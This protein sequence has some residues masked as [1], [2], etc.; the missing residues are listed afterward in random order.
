MNTIDATLD[1]QGDNK[2]Q[3][4]VA[5]GGHERQDGGPPQQPGLAW[6]FLVSVLVVAVFGAGFYTL[7]S[8]LETRKFDQLAF[9][10]VVKGET[11][12][13]SE[14]DKRR[15]EGILREDFDK[16]RSDTLESIESEVD[17]AVDVIFAGAID[18]IPDYVDW[19]YSMTASALKFAAHMSGDLDERLQSKIVELVLGGEGWLE[20]VYSLEESM[21]D[22]IL[23]RQ[24]ETRRALE[25]RVL[26]TFPDKVMTDEDNAHE[27]LPELNLS[28]LLSEAFKADRAD[29]QR[30]VQ[31]TSAGVLPA[32]ALTLGGRLVSASPVLRQSLVQVMRYAPS[33]I[34]RR[35]ATTG[36]TAAAGAVMTGPA[37]PIVGIGLGFTLFVGS[38]YAALEVQKMREGTQLAM[39]LEQTLVTAREELKADLKTRYTESLDQSVLQLQH[40]YQ[41]YLAEADPAGSFYVLD[42]FVR[43]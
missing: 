16:H 39:E 17:G 22:T 25:E 15:L 18:R 8:Y 23:D 36:A 30:W 43:H 20:N 34:A 38:E 26:F 3:A 10:V 41:G 35:A 42:G 28:V 27:E 24:Q 11:L 12:G 5:V 33:V 37:A 1:Q 21:A 29:Y 9:K 40:Q 14:R 4:E 32:A 13:L 7:I 2:E 19:H 31:S 6:W